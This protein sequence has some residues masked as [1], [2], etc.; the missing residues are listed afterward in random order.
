MASAGAGGVPVRAWLGTI[1]GGLTGTQEVYMALPE[2]SLRHLLEAGVHFG[3]TPRRWNPKMERYIFGVRNGVHIIDLEQSLPMLQEALG[4]LRNTA[5]GGGRFLFV[6]TKPQAASVV[7]EAAE[8]SAQYYV[9][10]R[11][12]GGMLTNWSSVSASIALLKDLNERLEN[13]DAEEQV[14]KK[15]RVRMVRKRDKLEKALGGIADMGGAPDALVVIDTNRESIAIAEA[16]RLSI[17]IVAP[18]DSNCDPELIDYP[19]PG[20]DDATRAITLYLDLASAAILDGVGEHLHKSSQTTN[21]DLGTMAGITESALAGG[22]PS[23]GTAESG[24]VAG[25]A[26]EATSEAV[27]ETTPETT[28]EAVP[29]SVEAGEGASAESVEI[30]R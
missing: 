23:A 21:E 24:S 16:R 13:T 1:R 6:G 4:F 8:R 29:E 9:N 30:S 17:P 15:E 28:P 25:A 10:H 11:W 22:V 20:N 12:L 5:A 14:K 27:S 18:V 26:P 3:H 19:I 2:T 7:R